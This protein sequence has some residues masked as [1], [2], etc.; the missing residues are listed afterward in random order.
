ML[1]LRYSSI[2][3]FCAFAFFSCKKEATSTAPSIEFVSITPS[4]VQVGKQ[5]VAITISYKDSDG[6]LGE[7]SADVKNMFV[8]DNRNGVVYQFRVQQLAPT[9]STI[10]IQGNLEISMPNTGITNGVSSEQ[11][12]F[13]IFVKDRAGNQSNIVSTS[14]ITVLQ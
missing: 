5:T 9:G 4:T 1:N 8:T 11:A 10:A 3:V 2:L 6:D 14:A 7:N 12:T 13:S